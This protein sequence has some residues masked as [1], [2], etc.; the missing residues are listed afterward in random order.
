M[1]VVCFGYKTCEAINKLYISVDRTEIVGVILLLCR[2]CGRNRPVRIAV[3]II[4]LNYTL[5]AD[6]HYALAI[7]KDLPGANFVYGED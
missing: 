2:A 4:S 6:D 7:F 5:A 1:S 3:N